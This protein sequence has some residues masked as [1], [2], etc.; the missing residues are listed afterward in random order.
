MPTLTH[1]SPALPPP[2]VLQIL[3]SNH[4]LPVALAKGYVARHLERQVADVQADRDAISRLTQET[5]GMR[6][7]VAK[8]KGQP[9]VFQNSR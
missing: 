8:M 7:E 5:A 2:Q 3:S 4:R 1:T 6:G 9:R